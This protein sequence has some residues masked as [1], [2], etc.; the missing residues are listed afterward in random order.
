MLSLYSNLPKIILF[1]KGVFMAKD[2]CAI[3]DRSISISVGF[4]SDYIGDFLQ[5]FGKSFGNDGHLA[6]P[7][8]YHSPNNARVIVK[9]TI[10][11]SEENNFYLFL[12]VF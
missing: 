5:T 4:S 3:M 2:S 8:E 6:V 9:V 1:K 10:P 12:V 7:D 11:D